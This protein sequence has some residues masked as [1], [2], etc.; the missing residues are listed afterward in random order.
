MTKIQ[1]RSVTSATTNPTTT[2]LTHVGQG[3]EGGSGG[4]YTA[5]HYINPQM[6][7]KTAFEGRERIHCPPLRA[8][9]AGGPA[10]RYFPPSFSER[11]IAAAQQDQKDWRPA[12]A[13]FSGGQ[14]GC[15]SNGVS[16]V[17]YS[18]VWVPRRISSA[19]L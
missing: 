5:S 16:R 15:A 6:A 11:S 4:S 12:P 19:R 7:A 2:Y 14:D 8:K 1:I 13:I 18:T 10:G 9:I 3:V 17:G